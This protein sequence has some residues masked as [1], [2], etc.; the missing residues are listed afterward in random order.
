MHPVRSYGKIVTA[1]T[2]FTG[3][4]GPVITGA[5][6]KFLQSCYAKRARPQHFAVDSVVT[7][8][9]RLP[10]KLGAGTLMAG[11]GCGR[12]RDMWGLCLAIRT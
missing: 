12:S 2:Y 1:L 3:P 6:A 11:C 9:K 8:Y 5:A 10:G 7:P 4:K